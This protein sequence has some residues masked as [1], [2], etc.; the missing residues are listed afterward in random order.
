MRITPAGTTE[1]LE[2]PAPSARVV[3]VTLWGHFTRPL[4]PAFWKALAWLN[5]AEQQENAF[6]RPSFGVLEETIYC[7]LGGYGIRAEV[8]HA[9]FER[10]VAEDV[11]GAEVVSEKRIQ[12]L[13]AEPIV[14]G[15]TK[16]SYRF[17]NQKARYIACAIRTINHGH[18]PSDDI[19]LRDWL[20]DLPGIGWKTAGWI[21][22]NHLGSDN[23]AIIDVH[24]HRAGQFMR[25]FDGRSL[26]PSTYRYFEERFLAFAQALDVRASCLDLLMWETLRTTSGLARQPGA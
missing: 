9:Y 24:L 22:R 5:R 20:L 13:L 11:L 21:V 1:V 7:L 8:A 4:T 17:P 19:G 18:L 12:R 15:Q 6:T 3:H 25:L 2:L 14:N 16:F 26:G 10:F 23:V